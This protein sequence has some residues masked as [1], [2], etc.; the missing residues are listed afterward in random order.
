MI[1]Y[2]FNLNKQIWLDCNQITKQVNANAHYVCILFVIDVGPEFDYLK[3]I[4]RFWNL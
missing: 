1:F 4:P 3:F 2:S